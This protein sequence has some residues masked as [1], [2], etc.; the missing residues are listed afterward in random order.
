MNSHECR[1]KMLRDKETADMLQKETE[2]NNISIMYS[3]S[4][5]KL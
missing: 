1:L 2:K 5:Y 4:T 3:T